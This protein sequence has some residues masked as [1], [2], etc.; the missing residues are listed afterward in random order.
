VLIEN[1]L[2]CIYLT[3]GEVY[4]I[5]N[6][7]KANNLMQYSNSEFGSIVDGTLHIINAETYEQ[8]T[9]PGTF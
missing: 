7:V 3:T 4:T 5:T 1:D 9:E 6:F 8:R 2:I